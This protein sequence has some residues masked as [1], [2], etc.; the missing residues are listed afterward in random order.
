MNVSFSTKNTEKKKTMVGAGAGA[1]VY[2][3]RVYYDLKSLFII[4]SYVSI[5]IKFI[6]Y[7]N[8]VIRNSC[9]RERRS[10]ARILVVYS[11]EF[12]KKKRQNKKPH[13]MYGGALCLCSRQSSPANRVER[14]QQPF[15]SKRRRHICLQ[16]DVYFVSMCLCLPVTESEPLSLLH[17]SVCVCVSTIITVRQHRT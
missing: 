11:N 8:V 10:R 2:D 5:Q 16:Y 15:Q 3:M 1:G 12:K 6:P 14:R 17:H 4:L 7:L 9:S 13:L